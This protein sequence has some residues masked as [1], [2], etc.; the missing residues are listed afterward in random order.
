MLP[1]LELENSL[2]EMLDVSISNIDSTKIFNWQAE[3]WAHILHSNLQSW[4]VSQKRCFTTLFFYWK[5]SRHYK[6]KRGQTME[7]FEK[8]SI[9]KGNLSDGSET[10]QWNYF[11]FQHWDVLL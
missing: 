5:I 7:K 9:N 8:V 4:P 6:P 3:K 1:S 11:L 10:E 2:E